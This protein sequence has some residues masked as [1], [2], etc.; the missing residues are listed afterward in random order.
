MTALTL[1]LP[2][3][4]STAVSALLGGAVLCGLEARTVSGE[5]GTA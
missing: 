3:R 2:R 4:Q 1:S 5:W